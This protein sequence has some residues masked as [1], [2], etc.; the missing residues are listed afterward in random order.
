MDSVI[1]PNGVRLRLRVSLLF[2]PL[3][4]SPLEFEDTSASI[5]DYTYGDRLCGNFGFPLEI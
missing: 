4:R 2:Q 5:S 3:F 1:H